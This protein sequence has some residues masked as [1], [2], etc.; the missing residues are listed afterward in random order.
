MLLEKITNPL[1]QFYLLFEEALEHSEKLA[2]ALEAFMFVVKT[3]NAYACDKLNILQGIVDRCAVV[4]SAEER[5]VKSFEALTTRAFAANEILTT[6]ELKWVNEFVT[7]KDKRIAIEVLLYRHMLGTQSTDELRLE[8]DWR[9]TETQKLAIVTNLFE[10]ED[11]V[12]KLS[13]KLRLAKEFGLELSDDELQRYTATLVHS[14]EYD[15]ADQVGMLNKDR[16]IALVVLNVNSGH[17]RDAQ[18]IATRYLSEHQE[19]LDELANIIAK[20]N[21][22]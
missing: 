16:A 4:V 5:M 7:S 22:S 8:H 21:Q 1:Y 12:L 20:I 10:A 19:I 15:K 18:D 6:A 17:L 14:R 11:N 9:L 13:R 3:R 2:L